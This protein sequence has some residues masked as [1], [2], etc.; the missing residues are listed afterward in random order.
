MYRQVRRAPTAALRPY[1]RELA[2][3]TAAA[4]ADLDGCD[5]A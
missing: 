5:P 1:G 3:A 2:D 4:H